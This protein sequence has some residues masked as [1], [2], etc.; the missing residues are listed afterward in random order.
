MQD[1]SEQITAGKKFVFSR[2]DICEREYWDDEMKQ[3][4][5]MGDTTLFPLDFLIWFINVTIL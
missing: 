4:N 3:K 5:A 1:T 2:C